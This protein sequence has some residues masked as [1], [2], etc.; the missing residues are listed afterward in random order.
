VPPSSA[1]IIYRPRRPNLIRHLFVLAVFF[2]AA[3]SAATRAH[4][5]DDYEIQVYGSET[6]F[7][8]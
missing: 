1:I 3:L 6:G 5:Q 2:S 8:R 4:A 7:L